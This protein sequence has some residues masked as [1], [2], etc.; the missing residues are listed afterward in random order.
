MA[1]V[2]MASFVISPYYPMEREIP[3]PIGELDLPL[4]VSFAKLF[5]RSLDVKA[6]GGRLKVTNN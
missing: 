4:N 5:S 3:N 1:F 2:W 6:V